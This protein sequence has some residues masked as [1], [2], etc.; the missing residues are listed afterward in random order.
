MVSTG[1]EPEITEAPTLP[2]PP[3]PPQPPQVAVSDGSEA[4]D[5]GATVER[6]LTNLVAASTAHELRAALLEAVAVRDVPSVAAEL[7]DARARLRALR[8]AHTPKVEDAAKRV[9]PKVEEDTSCV[10]CLEGVRTHAFLP[11]GHRAICGGCSAKLTTCPMCREPF[12]RVVR[13]YD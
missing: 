10:V 3:K 11:C 5:D 6:V 4:G 7:S 2:K 12:E 8:L 1:Q 9:Q 13:I